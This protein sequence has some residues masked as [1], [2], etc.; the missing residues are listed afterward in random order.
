MYGRQSDEAGEGERVRAQRRGVKVMG[1]L[2]AE[3]GVGELVDVARRGEAGEMR[4]SRLVF[5][6]VEDRGHLTEGEG[7]GGQFD[8][9]PP[10]V[11]IRH[12]HQLGTLRSSAEPSQ[13]SAMIVSDPCGPLHVT[14]VATRKHIQ[15][16]GEKAVGSQVSPGGALI[17]R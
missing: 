5:C 6:G 9:P 15:K 3:S 2:K 16:P 14:A 11:R 17:P 13:P 7:G 4:C 12:P 10:R 8:S 1:R